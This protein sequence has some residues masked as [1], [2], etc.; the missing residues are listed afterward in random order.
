MATVV[1]ATAIAA[2]PAIAQPRPHSNPEL[3]AKMRADVA[4]ANTAALE[5]YDA[6]NAA[7]DAGNLDDAAAGYRKAIELAPGVDHP[8]RRLCS[9]LMRQDRIAEAITECESAWAIDSTSA[10]DQ[11]ALAAALGIRNAPG[12][13]DRALQLAA[14]AAAGLPQDPD[15]LATWCQTL[16][17]ANRIPELRTCAYRL[18]VIEPDG[19][20]AN[21]LQT[22]LA[23]LDGRADDARRYLEKAHAAGLPDDEYQRIDAALR[24][25]SE[26]ADGGGL[27][28]H[29]GLLWIALWVFVGWLGVMVILLAAG[30]VLSRVTL[31]VATTTAADGGHGLRRIYKVVLA[32]SG[33]YFYL[34]IPILL[35][36]VVLTGGGAIYLC[37]AAGYVPIK[38]VLILGIIVIA[39]IGAILR[40]LFIRSKPADLGHRIDVGSEP[41]LAALLDEVAAAV[42]TRRPDAA[43]LTP[44]TD[45]AVTERAGLWA[46]VAGKR[47]ERSLIM[48]VALFDGMTQLQLKGVLAHEHGHYRNAD[49]AGGGFALAVRRSLLVMIIR[50]ARSGAASAINPVWWFLRGYHRVYL[51]VSQGASRLQEVLADRWA[52]QAY[53]SAAFV[54][55]YRHVIARTVEFERRSQTVLKDVLDLGRALPNLY[56]YEPSKAALATAPTA[57]DVQHAIDKALTEEPSLYDSHPAPQQRL[58]FAE[59]LAVTRAP[60]PGDDEPIWSLF[61]GGRDELE[62]LMTARIRDAVHDN[63]NITIPA[64]I[65]DEDPRVTN[66][67]AEQGG[68]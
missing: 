3:E 51:V 66:A 68:G 21:Y 64:T 57:A 12:D 4:A 59:A 1:V 16:L 8:H 40:S 32:L 53:G 30:F 47:T 65:A 45:M 60:A 55:G 48:G 52:V 33:I 36:L 41:A 25:G 13:L 50:M 46:S 39:T 14:D 31:R 10:Y 6:A 62:R 37:F 63:H 17:Q 44:G 18:A 54:A 11:S 23:G 7:R 35:A 20:V 5:P 61:S 49:T 27:G 2:A 26:A 19:I 67:R 28:A 22:M 15:V 56:Q 42:G 34:S 38:L 43:Y 29:A 58:A 24:A 9:V